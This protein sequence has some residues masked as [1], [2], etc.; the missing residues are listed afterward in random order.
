M[1]A[2]PGDRDEEG[3]HRC[4]SLW[5]GPR[6]PGQ[7]HPD[8]RA[9]PGAGPAGE[10]DRHVR[11][12]RTAGGQQPSVHLGQAVLQIGG[13]HHEGAANDGRRARYF[14]QQGSEQAAGQRFCGRHRE[15]P[16]RQQAQHGP[17]PILVDPQQRG[18]TG[19]RW[20]AGQGRLFVL[21]TNAVART[22]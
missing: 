22:R 2:R 17:E 8:G 12:H 3:A 18:Q 13:V 10:G 6:D 15:M 1:V 20:V 19:G 11:I 14:S 4:G 7:A 5:I 16:F 21:E 9:A